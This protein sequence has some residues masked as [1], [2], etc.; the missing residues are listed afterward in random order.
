M[1]RV[2]A[3]PMGAS[4]K[5]WQAESD[6]H[7]LMEACKIKKDKKRYEAAKK[8]AVKKKQEYADKIGEV[9]NVAESDNDD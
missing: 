4:E 1:A 9:A 3:Y 2:K 5:D 7:V 6:L 8:M